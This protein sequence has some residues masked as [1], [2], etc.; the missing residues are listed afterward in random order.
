MGSERRRR[1]SILLMAIG[2][3]TIIAILVSTFL[4]VSNLDAQEM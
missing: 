1:G 4:I 3:L 2:M